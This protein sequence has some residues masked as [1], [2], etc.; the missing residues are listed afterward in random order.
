MSPALTPGAGLRP[1][2]C[3]EAEEEGKADGR[4]EVGKTGLTWLSET[5][6]VRASLACAQDPKST[7]PQSLRPEPGSI[8][9]S[10]F[11]LQEDTGLGRFPN[12]N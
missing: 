3:M 8:F 7:R 5:P 4:G 2:L 12:Y 6:G 10:E 1:H 11:L 9:P